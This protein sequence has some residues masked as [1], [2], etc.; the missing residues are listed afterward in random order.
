METK[1]PKEKMPLINTVECLQGQDVEIIILSFVLNARYGSMEA[2]LPFVLEKHRL[3][4]MISRAKSK[5]LLLMSP[6]L[7]R[8]IPGILK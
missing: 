1:Y 7:N 6:D 2:Q 5:V 4:V 8:C 3:N